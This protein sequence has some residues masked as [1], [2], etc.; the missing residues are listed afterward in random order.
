MISPVRL[1]IV[2][3]G[4]YPRIGG[5][6]RLVGA[7][8]P[9]LQ[10][11]DFDVHVLTRRLPGT[12]SYERIDGVP[13]HRMPVFGPKAAASISFTAAAILRLLKIRPHVIHAHEMFSPAT[14][15]MLAQSLMGV[16]VIVTPHS[17]GPIGDVERIKR[18]FLG[19]QRLAFFRKRVNCFISISKDVDDELKGVGIL[20]ERRISIANGVDERRFSPVSANEKKQLQ[21]KLGLP[22][23]APIGLFCGRLAPEKRVDL[24]INAWAYIRNQYQQ[25]VLLIL[26][27]GSEEAY[28]RGIAKE[29]V[30]FRGPVDDVAPY[31]KASDFFCLP[32][33]R[34]GL[35]VAILE[36]Q[37]CALPVVATRIP[38]NCELIEHGVNGLLF[39]PDQQDQLIEELI[40][41]SGRPE[42]R[43]QFGE[44][45]RKRILEK[46][47]LQRTVE[48]HIRLYRQL[49]S[50]NGSLK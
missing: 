35:S 36:S 21:G 14:T 40:T 42:I 45:G 7:M 47:T 16:P 49:V 32:S 26:G 15:A 46:Y 18:R 41:M 30:D 17:S 10:E 1:A 33:I 44:A 25:A 50:S 37:A 13:V 23:D 19:Q 4:Y 22:Q 29:G 48:Q 28:L 9:R 12:Q 8:A 27:T 38:G 34:E 3:H 20:A 11:N 5:A 31:M 43:A 24:L 6:E 39:E 2:I